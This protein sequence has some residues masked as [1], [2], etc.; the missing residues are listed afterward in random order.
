MDDE[1][2]GVPADGR[3]AAGASA[4]RTPSGEVVRVLT[5]RESLSLSF[6]RIEE[7]GY[8]VSFLAALRIALG[9]GTESGV[10]GS[11][12]LRSR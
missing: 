5:L 3:I 8:R 11:M 2:L 6:L 10:S 1:G 12:L 9:S 4:L 7:S